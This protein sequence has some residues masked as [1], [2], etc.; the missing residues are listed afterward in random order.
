MNFIK[1]ELD[2]SYLNHLSEKVIPNSRLDSNRMLENI[3]RIYLIKYKNLK[4][5]KNLVI[6][7]NYSLLKWKIE[8]S[9]RNVKKLNI[10]FRK[11]I[12]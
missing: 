9:A 5:K 2:H 7:D 1:M 6:L 8:F 4:N 3:S 12:Y 11:I 10:A